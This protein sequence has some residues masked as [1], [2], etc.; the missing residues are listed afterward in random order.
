MRPPSVYAKPSCP[1]GC[2]CDVVGLLHGPHR[3]GARLVMILLS[4]QHWPPVAIAELLGCDP[5]TVRRWIHRYT[6][7]GVRGLEDRPPCGRPRLGSRRLGQRIRRLLA[8]PKA[9][10]IARLYQR[11][12]RP[13]MSLRT[14]H[15]RVR[16]VARWRRPRLV[17]KGDPNREAVLASLHHAIGEL[18]EGAVVLAEDETHI[19][20][21]PWVRATWIANGTRQQVMTPGT[22]RRRTIF[23]AVDLHTGRWFYQ[24]ARKAVS[25]TFIAFLD[26]LAA[27][28]PAAPT[29]AV[30][31]DNMII[32]HSPHDNP[33]ERIWGVLKAWLATSPTQILAT[34]APSSSPWMP[35]GYVQNFREAAE[36]QAGAARPSARLFEGDGGGDAGLERLLGGPAPATG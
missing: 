31:C 28:Y 32:H 14:L 21:L 25:A 12:G 24:V 20:L 30:V 11:L 8:E 6:Q 1:A 2:P 17:A 35:E 23:G 13:A 36:G 4:H 3:V 33:V 5:A 18:P 19:N 26:Q 15:R 22:N 9:W 34:A 10:T 7:D 27:G 29:V 16:E